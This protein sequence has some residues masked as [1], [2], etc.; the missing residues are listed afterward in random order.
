MLKV[1]PPSSSAEKACLLNMLPAYFPYLHAKR[2]DQKPCVLAKIWGFYT[3]KTTIF[4]SGKTTEV[5][6]IVMERVKVPNESRR[7]DLKGIPSRK[8]P[9][10]VYATKSESGTIH[11]NAQQAAPISI[12]GRADDITK[13]EHMEEAVVT[14]WDQEWLK[15]KKS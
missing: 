10:K 3:V 15:G 13:S 4:S 6:I 9:V 12:P 11:S 14:Q 1:I 8:L 5:D 2:E 7:F